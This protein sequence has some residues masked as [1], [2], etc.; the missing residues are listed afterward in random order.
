[1]QTW[2][3][4]LVMPGLNGGR[5]R[6]SLLWAPRN[7]IDLVL[8]DIWT[9]RNQVSA[10]RQTRRDASHQ[11]ATKRRPKHRSPCRATQIAEGRLGSLAPLPT[12]FGC[13]ARAM[14]PINRAVARIEVK[15]LVP[16]IR[17][18]NSP[19]RHNLTLW[20]VVSAS[21]RGC[22]PDLGGEIRIRRTSLTFWR[23]SGSDHLHFGIHRDN[24]GGPGCFRRAGLS[25][26]STS[27]RQTLGHLERSQCGSRRSCSHPVYRGALVAH[28]V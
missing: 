7:L 13:K 28:T 26:V 12:C 17:S 16:F 11:T 18:S 20:Q 21:Y 25:L 3:S 6:P 1:M 24:E 5:L 14:R 22:E 2:N 23:S 19:P 27:L 15:F 9:C 10:S 8:R 4:T